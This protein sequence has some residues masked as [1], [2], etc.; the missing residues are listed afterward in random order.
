MGKMKD[1]FVSVP[2]WKAWKFSQ[3]LKYG[4]PL[5]KGVEQLLKRKKGAFV[6][7]IHQGAIHEIASV[8][9]E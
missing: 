1:D 2:S 4:K 9:I 5:K 7:N 8:V 6:T 3:K